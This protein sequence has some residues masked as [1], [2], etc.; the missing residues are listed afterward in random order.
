[1]AKN[2]KP[3]NKN[4]TASKIARQ[5]IHSLLLYIYLLAKSLYFEWIVL[6]NSK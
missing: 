4:V 1:V 2:P 6:G 3:K 5:T